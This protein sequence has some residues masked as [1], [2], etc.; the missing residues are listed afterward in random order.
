MSRTAT[1]ESKTLRS[2]KWNNETLQLTFVS[3]KEYTYAKV[4]ESVF[5][6]LV[7][8]PS[9]GQFFAKHVRGHYVCQRQP[10]QTQE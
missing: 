2:A 9:A 1:F 4:S 10:E 6:Q 7:T 8:A 3:G 5:D